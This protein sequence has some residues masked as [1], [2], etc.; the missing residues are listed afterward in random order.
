LDRAER[1]G[2]GLL[3]SQAREEL[4]ATGA[5]PR[6]LV[7]SGAEALTASERRVAALASQGRTNRE[8]AQSLFVTTKTVETH[9][10]RVFSKL[11]IRSRT[12]IPG[13]LNT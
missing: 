4:L 6:R 7:F 10:A 5:R 9:L 3:A 2:A 8:I 13:H 1:T 11:G 12:E